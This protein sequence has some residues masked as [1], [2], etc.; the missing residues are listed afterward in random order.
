M[1]VARLTISIPDDLIDE[2]RGLAKERQTSLSGAVAMLVR[3]HRHRRMERLMAEG[4]LALAE[5]N[6][7]EVEASLP[8]Q[9]EVVL[10]D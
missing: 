2:L 8:A 4:Y 6:R 1:S 3:E 10:R 9:A 7:S 5:I